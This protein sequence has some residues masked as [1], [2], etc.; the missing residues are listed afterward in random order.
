MDG[1]DSRWYAQPS[2]HLALA[3]F[4]LMTELNQCLP[5]IPSTLGGEFRG[6]KRLPD[7]NDMSTLPG[8]PNVDMNTSIVSQSL[9]INPFYTNT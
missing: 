3:N 8:T 2:Y 7:P 4:Y 6:L 1:P 9:C 5:V